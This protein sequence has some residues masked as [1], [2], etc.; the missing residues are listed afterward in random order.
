[1]SIVKNPLD[2]DEIKC[3]KY[4]IM[5]NN[6]DLEQI[7]QLLDTKITPI[8]EEL[9]QHGKTLKQ[10]GKLL[11]SLKKDQDTMLD[12]LDSEQMQ[13]RNR[14]KQIEDHLGLQPSTS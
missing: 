5:L 12:M 10:H 4:F 14:L 13:Q 2:K 9:K 7:S 8:Q 11:R 3:Y 1:M 6:V